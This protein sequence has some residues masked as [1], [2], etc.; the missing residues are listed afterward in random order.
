MPKAP[1][2][3]GISFTFMFHSFFNALARSRYLSFFSH[4]FRFIL[5]FAGTAKSTVLQTMSFFYYYF[6]YYS[7]I[8]AFHISVDR[9]IFTGV[10][11]TA[12]PLK[13][14]GLFSVFLLFSIMLLLGWFP[15]V[16]QLP[17]PPVTLVI[18][19]YC[20]KRTNHNLYNCHLHIP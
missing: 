3:I 11:V 5:W 20:S 17:T 2:T 4:S 1:T 12:S 16:R 18:H 14:P 13:S 15:T 19:S 8:R 10:W 7:L 9:W 6:Y